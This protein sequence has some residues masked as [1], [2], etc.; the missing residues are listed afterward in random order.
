MYLLTLIF[1]DKRSCARRPDT[2]SRGGAVSD[3]WGGSGAP[4]T[5]KG[6]E[7]GATLSDQRD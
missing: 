1:L 3:S 7:S 5:E 4:Y 6:Q 2:Q